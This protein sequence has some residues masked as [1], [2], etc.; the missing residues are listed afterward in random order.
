MATGLISDISTNKTPCSGYIRV[1]TP[2]E[3]RGKQLFFSYADVLLPPKDKKYLEPG[4]IM[5]IT[6]DSSG[7]AVNIKP[8][9][10]AEYPGSVVRGPRPRASG[11]GFVVSLDSTL[12]HVKVSVESYNQL[13]LEAPPLPGDFCTV[14]IP[15]T[16]MLQAAKENR[17]VLADVTSFMRRPPRVSLGEI[18]R[19]RLDSESDSSIMEMDSGSTASLKSHDDSIEEH[20]EGNT[21]WAKPIFA[22]APKSR[23]EIRYRCRCLDTRTRC[24]YVRPAVYYST[25]DRTATFE[26]YVQANLRASNAPCMQGMHGVPVVSRC[27]GN[28]PTPF[29]DT[30]QPSAALVLTSHSRFTFTITGHMPYQN[31]Y[32]NSQ[33]CRVHGYI[34]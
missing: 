1:L 12:K 17:M 8:A 4:M 29:Y 5:D 33:G 9:P 19:K 26:Q 27:S 21:S 31:S 2:L 7:R 25:T 28:H 13:Q 10:M 20:S 30:L 32:S 16:E 3:L 24:R 11:H 6:I 22:H 34:S 23:Q 15:W 18:P 14:R